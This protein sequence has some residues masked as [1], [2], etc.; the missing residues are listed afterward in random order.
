[1]KNWI[2]FKLGK[3]SKVEYLLR[4]S[5]ELGKKADALREKRVG[6]R[7]DLNKELNNG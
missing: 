5:V 3:I 7:A 4:K 1:M 2:L 6:V